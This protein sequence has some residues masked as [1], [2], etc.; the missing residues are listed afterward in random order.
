MSE[1]QLVGW[2]TRMGGLLCVAV[3]TLLPMGATAQAWEQLPLVPTTTS[4][5]IH[6]IGF[7]RGEGASSVDPQSDSL[8][9]SHWGRMFLY[10]PSGAAGAAGP[11]GEWGA[12]YLLCQ[13]SYCSPSALV[14][15][16]SNSILYGSRD[17]LLSRS[18]NRG[19][20]WSTVSDSL[21]AIPLFESALPALAGAN[22]H[23][24]VAVVGDDGRVETSL[25]DGASGTWER[26]G[27][28]GGMAE[29]LGEVPPS[30]AL[31]TGRLLMGVWNGVTGSTDGGASF[32][33][34]SLYGFGRWIAYSFAFVPQ[35]GHPYS[36]VAF[37]AVLNTALLPSSPAGEIHRSDDGGLTWTLVHRFTGEETGLPLYRDPEGTSPDSYLLG[38]SALLATPDGVLWASVNSLPGGSVQPGVIMRSTDLGQ[39]WSRV[40]AGFEGYTGYQIPTPAAFGWRVRRFALS[41]TGVLYAATDYGVWRTTQPVVS[42]E[43]WPTPSSAG[44]A[45]AVAP[46]PSRGLVTLALSSREAQRARVSVVDVAGREVWAGETWATPEGASVSVDASSWASGVYVARASLGRHTEHVTA[47]FTVAR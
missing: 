10:N 32:Q 38:Q 6:G 43:A 7:L 2:A 1:S 11:N 24:L 16:A 27:L 28:G 30:A 15:T 22:G 21:Y 36:G 26:G 19:R 42:G 8:V 18:T 14:V 25:A 34:T 5:S 29:T 17:R 40:D 23:G 31:P 45:L 46:N 13:G 44:L 35:A 41:R 47:R 4:Q 12:W 39:T 20:T 37:A 33:P 9:M 3:L